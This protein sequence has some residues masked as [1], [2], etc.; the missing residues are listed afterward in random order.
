M[1]SNEDLKQ[2]EEIFE[3]AERKN[4]TLYS[5]FSWVEGAL[6]NFLEDIQKE[7]FEDSVKEGVLLY[8]KYLE[9]SSQVDEE[10]LNQLLVK[11]TLKEVKQEQQ[12]EK[13]DLYSFF[14][15]SIIIF[16][17]SNLEDF[18]DKLCL[19]INHSWVSFHQAEKEKKINSEIGIA[20]D[21]MDKQGLG[22]KDIKNILYKIKELIRIRNFLIHRLTS[23][24]AEK[25]IQES[26]SNKTGNLD[27]K[28]INREFCEQSIKLVDNVIS[29]IKNSFDIR[30]KTT[31]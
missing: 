17:C 28:N 10:T 7:Q 23:G 3:I 12:E 6:D 29:H 21:F 31:I 30:I 24:M 15:F 13:E 14:Y 20:L 16:L 8:R 26:E 4:R 18:L 27:Q 25:K 2:I 1:T 19:K 22:M 9:R 11:D 5:Y